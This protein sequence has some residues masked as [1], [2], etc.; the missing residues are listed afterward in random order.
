MLP[1]ET[2]LV[3]LRSPKGTVPSETPC[4]KELAPAV[5][6][7]TEPMDLGALRPFAEEVSSALRFLDF[8]HFAE[9]VK[10]STDAQVE[11]GSVVPKL[12]DGGRGN[13]FGA[14]GR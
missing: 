3:D 14:M 13:G 9:E 5:L 8:L 12:P 6:L 7:S 2:W 4:V 10:E 11:D 1:Y